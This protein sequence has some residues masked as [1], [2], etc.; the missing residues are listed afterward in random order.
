MECDLCGNELGNPHYQSDEGE[1]ICARCAGEERRIVW[2]SA[3]D[4][5]RLGFEVRIEKIGLLYAVVEII[6]EKEE[7]A[8]CTR[9]WDLALADAKAFRATLEAKLMVQ[10][11]LW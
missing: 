6:G 2:T 8:A 4:T 5:L 9:E 1:T 3:P 7:T 10:K 11:E